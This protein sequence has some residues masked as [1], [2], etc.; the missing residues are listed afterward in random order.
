MTTD[1]EQCQHCNT[2][3]GENEFQR[4]TCA[5]C[6]APLVKVYGRGEINVFNTVTNNESATLQ[7]EAFVQ[8][9]MIP[10]KY[11]NMNKAQRKWWLNGRQGAPPP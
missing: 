1:F 7:H 10:K 9:M 11:G 5:S 8:S 2:S 4:G 6:N 3:A